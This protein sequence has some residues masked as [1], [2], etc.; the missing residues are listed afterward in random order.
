MLRV[1]G[2][3]KFP[4]LCELRHTPPA[5]FLN[6]FSFVSDSKLPNARNP[7]S[8]VFQMFML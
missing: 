1:L 7:N 5:S 4:N 3:L 2:L 6:L 8:S